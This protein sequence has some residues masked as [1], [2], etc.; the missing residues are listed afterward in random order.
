L[1]GGCKNLLVVKISWSNLK[2]VAKTIFYSFGL[3]FIYICV[4]KLIIHFAI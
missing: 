3:L 4:D 1:L 2:F